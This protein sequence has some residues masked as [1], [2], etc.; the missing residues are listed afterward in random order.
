MS[1]YKFFVQVFTNHVATVFFKFF[2]IKCFHVFPTN[3]S[4]FI[5]LY[6][7]FHFKKIFKSITSREIIIMECSQEDVVNGNFTEFVMPSEP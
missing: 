6:S 5:F 3:A 7:K 2:K 4:M 1:I